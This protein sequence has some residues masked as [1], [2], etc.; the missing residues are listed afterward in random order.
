MVVRAAD[1]D[2]AVRKGTLVM[3]GKMTPAQARK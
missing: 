2:D 1:R 3:T